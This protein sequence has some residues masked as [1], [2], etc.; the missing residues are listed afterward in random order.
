MLGQSLYTLPGIR[1]T[2]VGTQELRLGVAYRQQAPMAGR[3]VSADI[4][5]VLLNQNA[6]ANYP[7]PEL[8]E[9]VNDFET[10]RTDGRSV[11]GLRATMWVH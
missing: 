8:P 5:N 10:K 4:R 6:V 11:S 7:P 2:V 1:P 3:L 9:V